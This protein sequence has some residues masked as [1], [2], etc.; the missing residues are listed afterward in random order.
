MMPC[1]AHRLDAHCVEDLHLPRRTSGVQ[2]IAPLLHRQREDRGRTGAHLSAAVFHHRE[3]RTGGQDGQYA[4][5][6]RPPDVRGARLCAGGTAATL[7]HRRVV[8]G[9][10]LRAAPELDCAHAYAATA[11]AAPVDIRSYGCGCGNGSSR[12]SGFSGSEEPPP[13]SCTA[14]DCQ[15]LMSLPP[16]TTYCP[17]ARA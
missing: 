10:V 3:L 11:D 15:L 2:S 17:G 1:L 14:H 6:R 8:A 16:A 9:N 12:F 13:G 4:D 5:G 7:Q